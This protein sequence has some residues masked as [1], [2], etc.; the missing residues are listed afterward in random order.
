M[1]IMT[2]SALN[3]RQILKKIDTFLRYADFG[4][5]YTVVISN[6]IVPNV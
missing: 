3:E 1:T 4:E 6:K 5:G 2:I